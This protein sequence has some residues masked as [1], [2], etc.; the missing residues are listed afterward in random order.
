MNPLSKKLRP[1]CSSVPQFP[2]NSLLQLSLSWV[3]HHWG[4]PPPSKVSRGVG[5]KGRRQRRNGIEGGWGN[6]EQGRQ[7]G[8]KTRWEREGKTCWVREVMPTWIF[9]S[10]SSYPHGYTGLVKDTQHFRQSL[11]ALSARHPQKG[12]EEV[13]F[14]LTGSFHLQYIC[15]LQCSYVLC[16]W[17]WSSRQA[18]RSEEGRTGA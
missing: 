5:A 1:P 8:G 12:P 3:V 4:L 7:N 10:H 9:V 14:T 16:I 17:Q 15:S 18:A 2:F 11:G 13:L 6:S